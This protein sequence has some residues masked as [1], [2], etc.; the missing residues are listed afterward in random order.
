MASA[1]PSSVKD[2]VDGILASEAPVL[3]KVKQLVEALTDCGLAYSMVVK[4]SEMLTHPDNRAGQMLSAMD[5]WNKGLKMWSVGVK[6]ELLTGSMA[7]ELALDPGAR[8]KQL[9]AN[10]KL[11]E[12]S[13]GLLAAI[14]GQERFLSVSS[15]HSTAWLKAV[16]AG[17]GGPDGMPLKLK[18][19]DSNGD[20]V[21]A[22][23]KDGWSW[24]I[25]SSAVE[26]EWPKLPC[27]LQMAL[28]STNA[29]NKQVSEIECA[30]QLAQGVLHGS[31]L[32]TA[33]D[34]LKACSPSC[35]N[36]LD[37][38]ATY[39]SKFGGGDK[40]ELVMFLLKFS[41]LAVQRETMVNAQEQ[42]EISILF[43]SFSLSFCPFHENES[44]TNVFD[45]IGD[46]WYPL[47][48]QGFCYCHDWGRDDESH[49]LFRPQR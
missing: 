6:Q 37:A 7:F 17:C 28:N 1:V 18:Q 21:Q 22:L 44:S 48:R 31:A 27:L 4:P 43:I 42:D 46:M 47:L 16:G 11:V 32:E 33:F 3:V 15:S 13:G 19:G 49:H 30:A 39:V 38:I 29:N 23:L 2:R 8:K 5:C 40:M 12:G 45:F 34:N 41:S 36:S 35:K 20:V 25:L 9:E 10:E 14:N 24:T 26:L